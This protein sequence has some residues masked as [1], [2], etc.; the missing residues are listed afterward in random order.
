M[1]LAVLP[2]VRIAVLFILVSS[3]AAAQEDDVP[4]IY[5]RPA[6]Q[7]AYEA[8]Q[9]WTPV[10]HTGWYA[11]VGVVGASLT[12]D[13]LQLS[14]GG[15]MSAWLGLHLT[16][17]FALELGWLGSLHASPLDVRSFQAVTTDARLFLARSMRADLYTQVGLGL[18]ALGPDFAAGIQAGVGVDYWVGNAVSINTRV[19]YRVADIYPS[20]VPDPKG[21]VSAVTFEAGTALHF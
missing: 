15:G 5:A 21:T 7:Q 4:P 2:P 12:S 1:R 8:A 3:T 6:F 20:D 17:R 16:E 10:S 11:G 18:Y 9:R 13:D 19:V 14:A